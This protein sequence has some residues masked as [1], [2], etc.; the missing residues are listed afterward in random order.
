M[1]P[2]LKGPTKKLL[3]VPRKI[4]RRHRDPSLHRFK[5][6]DRDLTATAR[7]ILVLKALD[8]PK[9]VQV[10]FLKHW[11]RGSPRLPE[12]APPKI[13]YRAER[14]RLRK[15]AG[16]CTVDHPVGAFLKSTAESYITATRMV[17]SAGTPV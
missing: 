11:H 7:K 13:D 4:P 5:T 16:A 14:N 12:V 1:H 3:F 8:W 17:E 15:V 9:R 6:L 10:E 2:E